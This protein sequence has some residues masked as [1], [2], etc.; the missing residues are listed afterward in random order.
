MN[1]YWERIEAGGVE[2]FLN[3]DFNEGHCGSRLEC[4]T[5]GC[6]GAIEGCYPS[7]PEVRMGFS[8]GIYNSVAGHK[9]PIAICFHIEDAN[10]IVSSLNHER[11]R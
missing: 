1:Y 3:I 2:D 10:K 5:E 6:E 11:S 7:E 4:P 9:Q 8:I